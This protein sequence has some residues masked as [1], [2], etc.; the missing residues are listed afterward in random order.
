MG[1]AAGHKSSGLQIPA[2]SK[3]QGG[4]GGYTPHSG[5][6]RDTARQAVAQD[7]LPEFNSRP[8]GQIASEVGTWARKARVPTAPD[9]SYHAWRVCGQRATAAVTLAC[10]GGGT[11]V[12]IQ[13]EAPEAQRG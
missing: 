11:A 1:R 9:D 8:P 7:G 2:V 3:E 5:G 12:T 4:K 13:E 6:M 10:T